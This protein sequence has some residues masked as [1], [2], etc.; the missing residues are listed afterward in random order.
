MRLP[1]YISVITDVHGMPVAE[2]FIVDQWYDDVLLIDVVGNR[3]QLRL[4]KDDQVS[5]QKV[6]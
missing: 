1:N 3:R 4:Q 6:S 5:R 2:G